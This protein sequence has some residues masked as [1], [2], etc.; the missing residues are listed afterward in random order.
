VIPISSHQDTVGPLCRSVAD[1][2]IV[3]SAIAGF[4]SL[5]NYTSAIPQPVPDYT[6]ALQKNALKGKRIGVPRKL[7]LDPVYSEVPQCQLDAF[8]EALET[9]KALGATVVDHA[10]IP[11]AMDLVEYNNG[12]VRVDFKVDWYQRLMYRR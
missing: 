6:K 3:L 2:A 9:I 5:D 1:A 8:E 10:D 7:F 12:V 4:D 11:S